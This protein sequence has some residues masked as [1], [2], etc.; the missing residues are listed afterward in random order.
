MDL[1]CGREE[2]A[3]ATLPMGL[4]SAVVRKEALLPE[5]TAAFAA[6]Q[7]LPVIQAATERHC[8]SLQGQ[9]C[10]SHICRELLVSAKLT[11]PSLLLQ[12]ILLIESRAAKQ[13]TRQAYCSNMHCLSACNTG[14]SVGP[15]GDVLLTVNQLCMARAARASALTCAGCKHGACHCQCRL[16]PVLLLV[17][18]CC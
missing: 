13:R 10:G 16:Y 14:L 1:P 9:Q 17:V 5:H 18:T 11:I 3:T 2:G 12:R 6:A 4:L 7:L 8:A 15:T